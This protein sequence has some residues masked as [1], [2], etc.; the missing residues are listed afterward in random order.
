MAQETIGSLA[1][2]TLKI[3][4]ETRRRDWRPYFEGVWRLTKTIEHYNGA[5]TATFDGSA[6]F[7]RNETALSYSESG[8]MRVADMVL[9]SEQKQNWR[10]PNFHVAEIDFADGRF[11]AAFDLS[12]DPAHATH[13]CPPDV[14][15]GTLRPEGPEQWRLIW[16]VKGPRKDYMSVAVYRREKTPLPD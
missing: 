14:Y 5:G 10:F 6:E 4:P 9:A 13:D 1:K 12:S 2:Q 7:T 8:A 3:T 16:R 15:R 11:L